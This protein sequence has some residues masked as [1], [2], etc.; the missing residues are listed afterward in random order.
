MLDVVGGRVDDAE[1]I[2]KA[3]GDPARVLAGTDCRFDTSAGM[4][5]V[6][7]DIVWAKLSSLVKGARLASQRLF[8]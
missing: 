4:G 5:R 3:F 8:A 2:A 6:S 7:E 1:H